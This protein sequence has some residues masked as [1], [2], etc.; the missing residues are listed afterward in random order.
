[1]HSL[2][3]PY[4][5]AT[6]A[7]AA[8]YAS[9]Q[10]PGTRL[11]DPRAF[12]AILR[13]HL[14]LFLGA[15]C[16]ILA[17]VAVV[18]LFQ[19]HR[20]TGST[21]VLLD[22]RQE[23]IAPKEVLSSLPAESNVVDTEVEVLNS[24][25]LSRRVVTALHLD[26]DPE[27]ARLGESSDRKRLARTVDAVSKKLSVRRASLTYVIN[28]SF[29]S[30]D[31]VKAALIANEFAQ[32]YLSQQVEAKQ[33]ATI[34]A[35]NWLAGRLAELRKQVLADDAAVQQ[36]KI[37]N[38]LQSAVGVNLTEQEIANY[39]QSLA[40]ARVQVAED[41][42][43]LETARAQLAAGSTGDDVGEALPASPVV[44]ESSGKHRASVSD[45][46]AV[47]QHDF[48]P[49][50]PPLDRAKAELADLDD[51]DRAGDQAEITNLDAKVRVSE[52][53][54]NAINANLSG[55]KGALTANSS[56]RNRSPERTR[57]QLPGLQTARR[58]AT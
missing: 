32:L 26:R 15:A 45:K 11:L 27:F 50:Y 57:A 56:W 38:N 24:P 34:N 8:P 47:L 3:V 37:A 16:A 20:Y 40:A 30:K 48:R 49:G 12:L 6:Y 46:V 10:P 21:E 22:P 7:E 43:R 31:P 17:I 58:R 25:E 14:H 28:L 5:E 36:Y 18:T 9:A 51:R 44:Q 52:R 13:R 39:N 19:P 4:A 29:T 54:A 2:P 33:G 41:R 23:Q 1:M 42:A 35:S 53:R 55:V